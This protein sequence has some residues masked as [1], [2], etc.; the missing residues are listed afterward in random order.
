MSSKKIIVVGAGIA[1][2]SAGCYLQMNGY[3]TEIFEAHNLPGGL[4]TAWKRKGYTI[5]GAIHG[6]LGSSPA[7]PFYSLWNEI[8]E[9]D[10]IDF[11]NYDV[12]AV[13]EF[14]DT[15]HFHLYSDL[16]KLEKYLRDISPEDGDAI[17]KFLNGVKRIGQMQMPVGKPKEFM[18]AFDYLKMIK[19]LPMLSFMKKWL[20]ISAEE[21]SKQFKSPLLQRAVR[22]FSSP[23]LFEMFVLYALNAKTSGYPKIGS[24]GFSKLI[25]KKYLALGGKINYNCKVTRINVENDKATGI[26]LVD[27][28]VHKA[29]IVI[30][31]CDGQTTLFNLLNGKYVDGSLVTAYKTMKLNS[32]RIQVAIGV[33]RIFKEPHLMKYILTRP[34]MIS[35]GSQF[36]T[37]DVQI[38][39]QIPSLAPPGKTLL[40]VQFE[41]NNGEYWIKLRAQDYQKYKQTKE[42]I[43]Q[44]VID[45]LDKKLGNICNNVEMIDV[46]TPA[47]YARYTGN[48]KGSIQG[49]ANE[50]IFEKNPFK[51]ELKGLSNFYM[52]GQWVEPGGGVPTVFKSGRD[53]AQIICKKEGVKFKTSFEETQ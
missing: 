42:E 15:Q 34:F 47:T 21:Y 48:W 22:E 40:E 46:V 38:F 35:D 8:I 37:L 51:K 32:S 36:S 2:L 43:A 16:I 9:M 27:G 14:E 53:L 30:S 11:V 25:E 33:A 23:I 17:D 4:C 5:E 1:G 50:K 41:T 45:F 24:L 12:Q 39:N 52:T 28:R 26:H 29:D 13:F 18:N 6:L 7:N 10:K 44:N 31:A 3:Q 49:W 20:K 19:Y